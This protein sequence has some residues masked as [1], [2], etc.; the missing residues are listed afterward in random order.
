[1]HTEKSSKKN[2]S[3]FRG[4]YIFQAKEDKLYRAKMNSGNLVIFIHAHTHTCI[5]L[6]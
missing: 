5:S 6:P 1:M 3:K 4:M 2:A